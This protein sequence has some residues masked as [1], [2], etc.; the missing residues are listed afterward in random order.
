[1]KNICESERNKLHRWGKFQLPNK[2]KKIGWAIIIGAFVLMIAKKFVD[3]PTWV[4][5]VLRNVMILGFLMVSI[6]KEKI[7]DELMASL[8]AT[9]Y[10]LALIIG[11]LYALIQPYV[12]YGIESLLDPANAKI[13][14]GYFQVLL[15]ILLVQIMFFHALK[16]SA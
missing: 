10:R 9:S 7:E 2:Y 14:N 8:R 1:M 6:S 5:P 12:T 4:K 13:D 3:E 15:Y 11:V 16:R